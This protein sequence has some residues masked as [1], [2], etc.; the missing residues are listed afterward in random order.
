MLR[1]P[2]ETSVVVRLLGA[3]AADIWLIVRL[4]PNW[5]TLGARVARPERWLAQAGTDGALTTVA[6]ALLWLAC[7]WLALGL[8][9]AWAAVIP[10]RAGR[11]AETIAR[12]IL[13][14]LLQRLVITSAGAS[15][16]FSSASAFAQTP[17]PSPPPVTSIVLHLPSDSVGVAAQPLTPTAPPPLATP[18]PAATGQAGQPAPAGKQAQQAQVEQSGR[19]QQTA[20]TVRVNPGD[21]LWLIEAHRLGPGATPARIARLWPA[22]YAANS[23]VIGSDPGLLRPGQTLTLPV[24][25]PS[26]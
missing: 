22:L 1:A 21:S 11:S 26:S 19:G 14:R 16:L 4:Q 8:L 3:A 7:C 6:S 2:Y 24:E 17:E 23:A 18:P 15:I 9:V 5:A 10:G 20:N 25:S 13:P 12:R